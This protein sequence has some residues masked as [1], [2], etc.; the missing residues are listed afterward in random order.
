MSAPVL[1]SFRLRPAIENDLPSVAGLLAQAKLAPLDDAAQFGSQYVVALDGHGRLAGV[2]GLEVYGSDALLRS[3]AVAPDARSNG[4][5][6][7]LTEDRLAW[8]AKQGIR[9]A[10]LLTTDARLYWERFG[11]VEVRRSDAPLG[12][13]ASTQWAGGCSAT[14][15]SMR[16]VL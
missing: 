3:V 10:F 14:A 4:L 8:A 5:G 15:T 16:K 6:R 1:T 2:A 12:I 13:R 9:Q 11:F 7:R